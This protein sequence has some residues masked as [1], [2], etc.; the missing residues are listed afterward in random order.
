MEFGCGW[1]VVG[2]RMVSATPRLLG[3]GSTTLWPKGVANHLSNGEGGGYGNPKI[4]NFFLLFFLKKII[5]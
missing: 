5:F 1:L 3:G 4:F 2:L